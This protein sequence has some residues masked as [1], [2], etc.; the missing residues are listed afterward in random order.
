MAQFLK[1]ND[2]TIKSPSEISHSYEVLDKAERTIDGTMV[3][4][5]IGRKRKVDVSWEYLSKEDMKILATET[6]TGT[7]VTVTFHDSI[8][9]A[10]TTITARPKDLVYQPYY[11]WAKSKILWKSVAISFVER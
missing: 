10:L 5:L 7:F 9:G 8:T 6:K 4:D 1:I 11:D 3:V 2:K